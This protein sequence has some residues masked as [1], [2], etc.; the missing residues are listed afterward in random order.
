MDWNWSLGSGNNSN[1]NSASSPST[2]GLDI[3]AQLL[4]NGGG[5]QDYSG[6]YNSPG[7]T[8]TT[9]NFLTTSTSDNETSPGNPASGVNPGGQATQ[10]YQQTL[11]ADGG[12]SS[13]PPG[14][15]RWHWDNVGKRWVSD[16]YSQ[17]GT[18][19]VLTPEERQAA[20]DADHRRASDTA[21]RAGGGGTDLN[22]QKVVFDARTK[23]WSLYDPNTKKWTDGIGQN[24]IYA[25]LT[26]TLHDENPEWWWGQTADSAV[27]G[28]LAEVNSQTSQY[29]QQQA[30]GRQQYRYPTFGLW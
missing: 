11:N 26:G 14:P 12:P 3:L 28:R 22:G 20:I 9:S 6:G 19:R 16:D 15:G 7:S 27:Q 8:G 29:G 23:T 21:A 4:G 5:R 18:G 2:S 24:D 1:N 17:D 30:G 10:P 25:M 13:P